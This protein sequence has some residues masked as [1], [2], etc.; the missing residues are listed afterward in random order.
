MQPQLKDEDKPK[1]QLINELAELRQ[2]EE[3]Y[4][5]TNQQL[6]EEIT[7]REH[8][9]EE[10]ETELQRLYSVL[11]ELPALVYLI[12]PDYSFRFYNRF[13]QQRF[14]DPDNK[15]CYKVFHSRT[16]PCE[17][18][19]TFNSGTV[20]CLEWDWN[21]YDGYTYH[22]FD[23]PFTDVDG[24]TMLL[25]FGIDVTDRI[26]AEKALRLS[27]EKFSKAFYGNPDLMAISTLAEGRYV[28][29]NDAF[30]GLTGYGRDE[31][32][33]HT[34]REL[35][36]WAV[37]GERDH[38]SKQ[39]QKDGSI[40]DFELQLSLKSG[41]IRT[42]LL[43]GERIDINGEPHLFNASKDITDRKRMEEALRLSEECFSKAFNVS[44]MVMTISTLEDGRYINFNNAFCSNFGCSREELIGK[45]SLEMGLWFDPSDRSLVKQMI[46]ENQSI[47][48]MEFYFC[49]N[50]REQRLGSYSA[51]G[52][53]VNGEPCILSIITDITEQK[54]M[55]IEMLRMDRLNLVGEMAASIGHEIRNPMTA[56]RGFLQ[57]F[58]Y[59]YIEDKEFIDL[60]IEELDRANGIISEFLYLAKNKMVKLMPLNLNSV[61]KNIMPL[62]KASAAIQDKVIKVKMEEV[63]ELLL[64]E[65]E[66]RQLIFNLVNNGM[67]SMSLGGEV[68]IKTSVENDNVVLAVQDQGKGIDKDLLKHLGTPFLTTKE[69][70]TGLGLAV[71][72][73]IAARHNAK[74]EIDTNSTGTTFYV[75][76]ASTVEAP[77]R[78]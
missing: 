25:S 6:K 40:R 55:E 61:L 41:E 19:P 67:E 62:V 58:Q 78:K 42:F 60:M 11:N 71:C 66:I 17:G 64:D 30:V 70:G 23:F 27:E 56:V 21:Y 3:R 72:Y 38:L 34:V 36:I 14:G 68:S 39:I 50:N 31:V 13:F 10:L 74:I 8:R 28:E 29:I 24:T 2:S 32:I 1:E 75:R 51:V 48:D 22:T 76:F 37:P 45:T 52:L 63:P 77:P 15:H 54:Q 69:E 44:P 18:C 26:K 73:R 59:K 43:S 20:N 35:G 46:M 53:D 12:A 16:I 33:G 65:N 4:R 49:T 47:Q 57:L 5:R 7:K 9:E